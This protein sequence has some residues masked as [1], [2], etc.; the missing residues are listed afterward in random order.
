VIDVLLTT[1]MLVAT[2]DP[3]ATLAPARKFVPVMVTEVPPLVVPVLGDTEVTVGGCGGGGPP[4]FGNI[5]LS[6]LRAPGDVCK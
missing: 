6:F 5:V 1:V 2:K 4:D 3:N